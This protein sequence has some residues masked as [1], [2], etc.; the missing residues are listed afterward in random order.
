MTDLDRLEQLHTELRQ[1]RA[2]IADLE[3]TLSGATESARKSWLFAERLCAERDA[4][5]A[6]IERVRAV[7]EPIQA[8]HYGRTTST[9]TRVCTGCGTDSGNWQTWPCPTIR[10]LDGA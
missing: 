9:P 6:T 1:A 5:R 7:H 4:A 3:R 2:T 10:A 8:V